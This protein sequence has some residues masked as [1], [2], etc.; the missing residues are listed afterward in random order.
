MER[1]YYFSED[2]ITILMIDS[3]NRKAQVTVI[4]HYRH[5][6][7]VVTIKVGGSLEVAI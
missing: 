1:V 6:G 5:K 7:C 3:Q 4:D 2:S